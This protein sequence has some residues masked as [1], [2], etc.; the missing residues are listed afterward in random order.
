VNSVYGNIGFSAFWPNGGQFCERLASSV[1]N[2][3]RSVTEAEGRSEAELDIL[4]RT[5]QSL[6]ELAG[7][8]TKRRE[9]MFPRILACSVENGWP[10]P[11]RMASSMCNCTISVAGHER[12]IDRGLYSNLFPYSQIPQFPLVSP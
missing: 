5:G 11:A 7:V 8:R 1:E 9:P 3:Q 2:G 12:I 10:V 4:H 6:T